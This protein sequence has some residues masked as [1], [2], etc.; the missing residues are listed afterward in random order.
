MV[1]DADVRIVDCREVDDVIIGGDRLA[2]GIGEELGRVSQ[3]LDQPGEDLLLVQV[4]VEE[5]GQLREAVVIFPGQRTAG[6][7][8]GLRLRNKR[9]PSRVYVGRLVKH[10]RL[11]LSEL[12]A[13]RK[14]ILRDVMR[15]VGLLLYF[16]LCSFF[17]L[18][19]CEFCAQL[20]VLRG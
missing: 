12:R 8:F 1:V 5:V 6:A 2:A 10:R 15:Y 17:L 3:T 20:S 19:G 11:V 18:K 9:L 4:A 14:R 13:L 16:W 7:P